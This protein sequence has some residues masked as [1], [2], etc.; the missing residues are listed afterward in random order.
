[1]ENDLLKITAQNA[2]AQ[3]AA[4]VR[5]SLT[6]NTFYLC[7]VE[8][9]MANKNRETRVRAI[10]RLLSLFDTVGVLIYFYYSKLICFRD[11][12]G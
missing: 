10:I 8:W 2:E 7:G 12:H 4:F 1:M 5:S 6:R 9:Q 3:F 11:R